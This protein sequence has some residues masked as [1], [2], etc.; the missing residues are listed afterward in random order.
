MSDLFAILFRFRRYSYAFTADVSE[1]FLR[2]RL[3]ES[4]KR[5]HRFWWNDSFWQWN[6][7]LFGNRASVDIS[8]KAITS[9]AINLRDSYPE[10]C[11]ALI[12]DTYMDDTIVRL[13][14]EEDCVK[15]VEDL[16]KVTE[17]METKIQKFYSNSKLT[18]KSLPKDLLS[19]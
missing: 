16:P 10:A 7:I 5:Y 4:D 14:S 6:R 17:G 19:S 18:L 12:D 11:L 2:I 8:Q 3:T 9:H 15:L 1:M 13:P